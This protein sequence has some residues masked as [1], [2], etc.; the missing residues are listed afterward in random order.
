MPLK[1][2]TR[3]ILVSTNVAGVAYHCHGFIFPGPHSSNGQSDV[4]NCKKESFEDAVHVNNS[5]LASGAVAADLLLTAG[6]SS[7][8]DSASGTDNQYESTVSITMIPRAA[9]RRRRGRLCARTPACGAR[10]DRRRDGRPAAL[11][12]AVSV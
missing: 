4:I 3:E 7:I 5:G 11:G 9:L 10:F 8:V 12:Q 6:L 1:L 2:L